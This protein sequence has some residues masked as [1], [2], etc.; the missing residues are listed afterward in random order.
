[1]SDR[2]G[3]FFESVSKEI[4]LLV[5]IVVAVVLPIRAFVAQPFVV[6][7]LS[8]H[9]TFE[10]GDYLIIDEFTYHFE[11]PER[12]DV[13]VFR[14]PGDPSVFYIKRIIGLP[15]ETV[16][17]K[18]GEVSVTT[19]DGA[20]VTLPEPYVVAEDVTYTL[21]TTLGPEQY[22]V[23]G[24]NR[25]K[26][27]DSRMWGPLPRENITGRAFVRLLP[28]TDIELFPGAIDSL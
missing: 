16:S 12:G 6:D 26:S 25:P 13:V 5:A 27:S 22:F 14:Y 24:D 9:P 2:T 11:S 28:V 7:G 10:H 23:M 21:E 15:G 20:V 8:M 19:E 3:K 17:I 4:L 1:M 18:R